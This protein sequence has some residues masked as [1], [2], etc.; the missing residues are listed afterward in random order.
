MVKQAERETEHSAQSTANIKNGWRHT[1]APA[2][3]FHSVHRDN[4][5]LYFLVCTSYL[6]LR[7]LLIKYSFLTAQ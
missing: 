5:T 1:S 2:V 7:I 6:V 3:F 4:F